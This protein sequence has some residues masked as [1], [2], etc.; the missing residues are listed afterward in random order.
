MSLSTQKEEQIISK[1][2]AF[3]YKV[4]RHTYNLECLKHY[5]L[6]LRVYKNEMELSTILA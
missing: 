2:Q 3:A 1:Y 5:S 6:I 4:E